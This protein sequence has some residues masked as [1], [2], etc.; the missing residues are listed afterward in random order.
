V[1]QLYV[2]R[3]LG[4]YGA[5]VNRGNALLKILLP[6]LAQG[7]PMRE[8]YFEVYYLFVECYYKY[9]Q[10]KK[11]PE[12]RRTAI[13]KAAQYYVKL[14]SNNPTLGGEESAQRFKD[15]LDSDD[16]KE[17]KAAVEALGNATPAATGTKDKGQERP[18]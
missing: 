14:K 2:F 11:T 9:G 6:K 10:S 13:A 17:L 7:G 8:R 12:E 5:A 18:R 1:E 4:Y 3:D 15:L 16:G